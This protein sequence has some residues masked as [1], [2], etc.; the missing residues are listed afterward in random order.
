MAGMDKSSDAAEPDPKKVFIV[1]GHDEHMKEAAA[2]VL[3][4]FG[5]MPII[6]HEQANEGNTLMEKL[7]E[8]SEAGFA[9]VLL[10]GDDMAYPVAQHGK[11]PTA[12]PRARQN[13]VLE[14]GLF[15]GK[16]AVQR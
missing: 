6:L 15:M 8:H 4:D 11:N 9:V 14:L 3:S 7:E 12:R 2:R 16:L 5:L 13:V 10:S 1:H